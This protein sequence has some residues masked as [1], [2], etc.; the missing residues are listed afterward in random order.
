MLL[1]KQ[2]VPWIRVDGAGDCC[3][4]HVIDH[5][6]RDGRRPLLW[7]GPESRSLSLPVSMLCALR[8]VRFGCSRDFLQE[9]SPLSTDTDTHSEW[10][11]KIFPFIAREFSNSD[12]PA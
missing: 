8:L 6:G 3:S 12:S 7:C 5:S 9:D 1:T 4:K 11:I 10:S 2:R